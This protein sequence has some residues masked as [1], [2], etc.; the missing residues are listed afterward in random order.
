MSEWNFVV[1]AYA[2]AWA[3]LIGYGI[4][5]AAVSRRAGALLARETERGA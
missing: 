3:G 5:L 1:A 2:V 4:R